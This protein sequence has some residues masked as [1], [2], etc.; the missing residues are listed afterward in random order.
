MLARAERTPP[1]H[2]QRLLYLDPERPRLARATVLNATAGLFAG[3]CF[4]LAV[5][6]DTGAAVELT[7]P[8]MTRV[9]GMPQGE[10]G[11]SLRI[12]AAAGSY[13]EYLPEPTLLC[14]A[15]SLTQRTLVDIEE[16]ATAAVGDVVAFGRL[17]A[18]ERH[19]FRGLDQRNE[20]RAAGETILA[21][22]LQLTPA[23]SP[24]AAGVLGAYG[25]YGSLQIVA[26]EQTIGTL[27]T[28]VR[29]PFAQR[30]DL[31]GGASLLPAHAGIAVRVL[32]GA[33][34]AVH[35]VLRA[36]LDRVRALCCPRA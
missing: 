4:D 29:A 15:A 2:V 27:L 20:F 28:E 16:G 23:Q 8:A 32:G 12:S 9:F 13:L 11:V 18:G 5:T 21:E 22:R 17:A 6:L 35:R 1:F 33:P 34:H 3:D 19:A 36:I 10:A 25:T 14:R 31:L 24:D 30:G 7:T 26:E